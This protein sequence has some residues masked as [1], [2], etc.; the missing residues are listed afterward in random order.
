LSSKPE[1]FG[2]DL[3]EPSTPCWL[4]HLDSSF[5]RSPKSPDFSHSS[6]S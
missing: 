1:R 5:R 3:T 2:Q 6:L 4:G